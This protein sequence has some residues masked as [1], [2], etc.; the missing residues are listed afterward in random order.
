MLAKALAHYFESKLLLLDVTDF[1]I[2]VITVA[3]SLV[4]SNKRVV[5]KLLSFLLIDTDAKQVRLHQEG[6][7]TLLC[8]HML[9]S[10]TLSFCTDGVIV[11]LFHSYCLL[12]SQEVYF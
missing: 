8:D 9:C 6:T 3:Y 12:V 10:L 1:S 2:K 7:C 11:F 5:S 4:I